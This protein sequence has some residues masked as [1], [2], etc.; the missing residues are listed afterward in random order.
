MSTFGGERG[1]LLCEFSLV[2]RLAI[3]FF[4][5]G[6]LVVNRVIAVGVWRGSWM[7]KIFLQ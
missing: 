4:R 2:N 1:R 3:V 6:E 7:K 5:Q